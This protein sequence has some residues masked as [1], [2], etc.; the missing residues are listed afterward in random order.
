VLKAHRLVYHATLG[1]K[2][3]TKKKTPLQR[4]R[5]RVDAPEGL[6]SRRPRTSLS[7]S[8]SDSFSLLHSLSPLQ[9]IGEGVDAPAVLASARPVPRE[10]VHQ[11][12]WL[13]PALRLCV[14]VSV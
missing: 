7:L 11:H 13:A 9:G 4:V 8:L 10:G 3:I 6:A 2:V 12:H 1:S 14:C 5:E